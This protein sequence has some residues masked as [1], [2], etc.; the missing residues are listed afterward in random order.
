MKPHY[1]IVV[2]TVTDGHRFHCSSCKTFPM[3][4]PSTL[5]WEAFTAPA[6]VSSSTGA[7]V[8][9]PTLS[10][11]KADM[12][13]RAGKRRIITLLQHF[14]TSTVGWYKRR[15]APGSRAR[16]AVGGELSYASVCVCE[17][18]SVI[19]LFTQRGVV[20]ES[21]KPWRY[22]VSC[23]GAR[24]GRLRCGCTESQRINASLEKRPG[25]NKDNFP[26]GVYIPAEPPTIT[27]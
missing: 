3:T 9:L 1:G 27:I 14:A 24:D 8:L 20:H 10:D 26:L 18:C 15:H 11:T 6:A 22:C 25:P 5:L 7:A 13:V 16:P 4:Y 2:T 19:H 23:C 21:G 12:T 17:V